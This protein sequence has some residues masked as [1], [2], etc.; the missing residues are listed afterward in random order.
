MN[1]FRHLETCLITRSR[2]LL[3]PNWRELRIGYHMKLNVIRF[4][5]M[6]RYTG[7]PNSAC[8]YFRPSI[9]AM[10]I[11]CGYYVC[12]VLSGTCIIVAISVQSN[13]RLLH[14]PTGETSTAVCWSTFLE[15]WLKMILGLKVL[16]KI[17]KILFH[18][19]MPHNMLILYFRLP[20]FHVS[21]SA[22]FS[23]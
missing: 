12:R 16:H 21:N 10:R 1:H 3:M 14:D 4:A 8:I 22:L 11:I 2:L 5:K 17:R 19:L 13:L 7:T 6:R 20:F 9:F 23:T 18:I 15:I